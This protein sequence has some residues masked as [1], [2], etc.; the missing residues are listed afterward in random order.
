MKLFIEN[1]GKFREASI[2]INGITVIAGENNTGKSTLGKVLYCLFTSM[3][4]IENKCAIEKFQYIDEKARKFLKENKNDSGSLVLNRLRRLVRKQFRNETHIDFKAYIEKTIDNIRK[5][6]D[7]YEEDKLKKL[8]IDLESVLDID[9]NEF[10]MSIFSDF[11]NQEF[12]NQFAN[13]K[14]PYP[15][16]KF[17]ISGEEFVVKAKNNNFETNIL[18]HSSNE[19]VYIDNPFVIDSQD[20]L[21][22]W[23]F[24]E[25][26]HQRKLYDKFY[27]KGTQ[28]NKFDEILY[29]KK[30]DKVLEQINNVVAGQFKEDGSELMFLEQGFDKPF[31]LKNLST[32]VKTFVIFKRLLEMQLIQENGVIV[33]DEPEIHLHPAWQLLLAE[34][35]VIL[36]T[37]FNLHVLITT[38]SPYFLN[39]IEVFTAKYSIADRCRYYL[40]SVDNDSYAYIK[41]VTNSTDEIY[42]LLA[43]PMKRLSVLTNEVRKN[44][45]N[46]G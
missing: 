15:T 37:E 2:D 43:M 31:H 1:V 21:F 6:H 35:I 33:L 17:V 28:H 19:V 7:F 29:F 41:D 25:E 14:N 9:L 36:Q 20:V 13:I 5:E 8:K 34:I 23:S 39:A 10:A 12:K 32:G 40:T 11:V 45:T 26:N 30:A 3:Y 38:H 18:F 27:G 44:N 24:S 46:E 42:Y 4:D 22:P 16:L